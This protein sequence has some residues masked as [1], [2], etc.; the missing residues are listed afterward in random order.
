MKTEEARLLGARVL[1]LIEGGNVEEAYTLLTPTLAERTPFSMLGLL[2]S[3]VGGG[4]LTEVTGFLEIVAAEGTMGGWVIIGTALEQQLG[5]DLPGAFERCRMYVVE[6][7]VWYSTDILAERVPGP[8]LV[9]GFEP[10]LTLLAAWRDD[11][12]RWVRRAVGVA[13][14]FWAKR[15][16]GAP[17]L[18]PRARL[19]LEFLEPMF[20]EWDIDAVKGIGWG[21]KTL[22]RYYP[23]L[24]AEWLVQDVLVQQR[25]YRAVML[26]KAKMGLTQEQQV[27]ISRQF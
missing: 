20:W 25:K 4:S 17:E 16:R 14:H 9:A 1:D 15:S 10:A 7:S 5:R 23:D 11:S 13:V 26:R 19:L 3:V 12:V 6:G 24:V 21:L 22:G 8:A 2:G 27:W 18:A